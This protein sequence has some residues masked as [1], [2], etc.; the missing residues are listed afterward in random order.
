MPLSFIRHG[1]A[2][3]RGTAFF[4]VEGFDIWCARTDEVRL[5]EGLSTQ[6]EIA[7][8]CRRLLG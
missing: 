7:H 3:Q 2:G 5:I 6:E 1:R 4:A 8:I